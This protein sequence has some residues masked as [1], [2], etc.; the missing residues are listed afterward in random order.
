MAL[1][2]RT[3]GLC[4][5]FGTAL[6]VVCMATQPTSAQARLK[7]SIGFASSSLPASAARIAQQ[8]GLFEKNGL[9]A[10]LTLMDSA[11]V[12]SMA[13]ISGSVD[14]SVTAASEVI[15]AHARGQKLLVVANMYSGYSPVLVVSKALAERAKL[16]PDAS[17][18]ARLK[19]LDG[20]T[21]ASVSATS[22][23]TLGLKCAADMVGAK[24]RF[25]YMAQPA[26]VAALDSGAVEGI[27]AGSPYYAAPVRK[28]SGHSWIS[29][30]KGEYP[31]KCSLRSAAALNTTQAYADTHKEEIKR[32]RAALADLGKTV[33][34]RPAE[35]K[36]AIAQ[37]FSTVDAPTL[38]LLFDS[39]GAN[40]NTDAL[41][42][43][44]LAKE[45]AFVKAS[46]A[47]VPGLEKIDPAVL[48]LP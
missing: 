10:K 47:T 2:S 23:Y 24:I 40:F 35:V 9:D 48:I 5:A 1:R 33:K 42:P 34:E 31:E 20:A 21:I 41:K 13:L 17:I 8:L 14:F 3:L 11:N 45:I 27:V 46:G 26:M 18:E 12:A 16:S 19:A 4:T 43:E 15:L 38:D 28:G 7:V 22:N 37:L 29:G 39:E 30:P 25:T 36:A 6:A 32:V 44:D